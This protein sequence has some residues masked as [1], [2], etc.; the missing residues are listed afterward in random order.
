MKLTPIDVHLIAGQ[1]N[2]VGCTNLST[3]PTDFQKETFD[4]AI[5]YEEGNFSLP[6][7][8]KLIRGVS[9]GMGNNPSQMGIEYGISKVLQKKYDRPFALLRYAFGGSNLFW[10][11][12][13]RT[14]WE[15][16]PITFGHPGFHYKKWSEAVYRGRSA[17]I[18]AG[19]LPE[20]KSLVW[21]QG[22]S[23]SDKDA[24]I[25]NAYYEN[26]CDLFD[27]MKA[28]L[29]DSDPVLFIGEIATN[30]P[31]A[32]Y[33]ETVRGAQRRYSVTHTNSITISTRDLPIGKDGLHFDAPED[34]LLGIRFGEAI[35][36]TV[37]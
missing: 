29:F 37:L 24:A 23:D 18:E 27:C 8:G 35:G 10:D 16:E 7:C 15:G 12:I 9:L 33:S 13:P 5:L 31:V 20:I 11:W 17:L 36:K 6:M 25:A 32:P 21:M 1:S 28:E 22:E 2:A 3:L 4:R 30:A 26:L 34:L 14:K 19:F